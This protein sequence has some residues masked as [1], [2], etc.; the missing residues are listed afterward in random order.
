MPKRVPV[1]SVIVHR[2][3]LG[4]FCPPLGEPFE[5]T[6]AEIAQIDK[7]NPGALSDMAQ[8]NLKDEKK[9]VAPGGDKKPPEL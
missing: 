1:Q 6:D 5:F 7:M 8:V 2:K 3:E 4:S 9:A